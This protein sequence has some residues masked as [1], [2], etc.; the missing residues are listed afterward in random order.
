MSLGADSEVSPVRQLCHLPGDHGTDTVLLTS[1]GTLVRVDADGCTVWIAALN[2]VCGNPGGTWLSVT[3]VDPEIVCLSSS[4][5]IVTVTPIDGQIELVGEFE[6]GLEAGVWSPDREVLSLFTFVDNGEGG[7]NSVLL[8]MNA[9]LEVLAEVVVEENVVAPAEE[10]ESAVSMVW[11]PDGTLC[12]VS[13]VDSSDNV[14]RIRT[15]SREDL[16]LHSVGR[17]E[18]GSGKV[19]PNLLEHVAWA[20]GGCSNLM[21]AVQKKGKRIQQVVFF[22][23]NGLRHREFPLRPETNSQVHATVLGLT[24]N[25]ESDLLAISLREETHDKVQLWHRSNYHWY[26]KKEIRFENEQ[27][28]FV[29]FDLERSHVLYVALES[30]RSCELHWREYDFC[31]DSSTVYTTVNQTARCTAFSIDGCL[32][33][34]T[35]FDKA[36][37]PPPMYAATLT[38]D[39][40]VSEISFVPVESTAVNVVVYL[41]DGTFELLGD[42]EGS[43]NGGTSR[44]VGSVRWEGTNDVDVTSLRQICVM[45]TDDLSLDLIAVACA[46]V[47]GHCERLVEVHIEWDIRGEGTATVIKS[48]HLEGRALRVIHWSDRREGALIQLDDGILLE[49]DKDKMGQGRLLPSEAEPLLEACPWI[50]ALHDA[51]T[52]EG[53]SDHHRKRLVVGRSQRA[54]LY[55]HDR[56]LAD[57]SSSFLLAPSH[58]Y[59]CYITADATCQLRFLPLN[60]LH[61]FD[62]LMGSDENHLLQGYEARNVE[63]GARLVGVLPTKPTSILQMP[64]GNLEAVYPRALVLPYVMSKIKRLEYGEAFVTMRR[65]KVDLNLIVDMDPVHFLEQ[66][67]VEMFLEQVL[68]IDHLNLFISCLQDFDVTVTRYSV[69]AWF[70][71][72]GM[73]EK[74]PDA[75][76][77]VNRVCRVMRQ[78]MLTTEQ[79]G[80]TVGGRQISQGHY[81]LPILSTFAKENP[82]KL[83]EAL[84]LIKQNALSAHPVTSRKPPLFGEKAQ[85]S[86]K[87]LAFLADY[88]LLF[89]TALGMYDFDLSR[90]VA[91]NS[92]MDPKVYLPLLKRLK[93][94]PEHYGKYEVDIR[95]KRYELALAHLVKSGSSGEQ[96]EPFKKLLEGPD[97]FGNEFEQCM[98]LIESQALHRLGLELFEEDQQKRRV[99]LISLGKHLLAK[100]SADTALAVFLSA[101]PPDYEGAKLAARGSGNWRYYFSVGMASEESIQ[102]IE[103][104]N[105][106]AAYDIADEIAAGKDGTMD[107]RA[108]LAQ[109]ARILLDY[110]EDI[111]GAIDMLLRAEMWSE[112]RRISCLHSRH[113]LVKKCIGAA[114][115]FAQSSLDDFEMRKEEFRT[116]NERYIEVLKIRKAAIRESDLPPGD[117]F[118]THID[119]N[120][121]LF[122]MASN[123]SNTSVRS[124]MSG[125]SVGSVTSVSSVI[126][127]SAQSTFSITSEHDHYRHKS[128]FN[129]IGQEKKKKKKKK[130][131][132]GRKKMQPGSEEELNSLVGTLKQSCVNASFASVISD[133]VAYLIEVGKL[134]LA[135]ELYDGYTSMRLMIVE[136]Q[137]ER[138]DAARKEEED[139]ERRARKEGIGEMYIRHPVEA[140]VDNLKCP[141]L[142]SSTQEFFSFLY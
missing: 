13:S 27:M 140:D 33:N 4:G 91:R 53:A 66:G 9:Q 80:S 141:E 130:K 15:Y 65:Q 96:L 81:L 113:D 11:R 61:R 46:P 103:D 32:L 29:S 119:D 26:L 45:N 76:Q 59:L 73:V 52:Y 117:A 135:K 77:K 122:S 42:V 128:K 28:T 142:A 8:S 132:T 2:S 87:Y 63:R 93:E 71:Q 35:H 101:D 40:P 14:R 75:V 41:S 70:D 97:S 34:M 133:T 95:L 134:A 118:D 124:N 107:N 82:P 36:L 68:P 7:K 69:P 38:M 5:A 125:S 56:L 111:V 88:K 39:S 123:A 60:E 57:S 58:N 98:N 104:S 25:T 131:S 3:Y 67:G 89:D 92:Q 20:G 136:L 51:A 72:K 31:W 54:R 43:K 6:H 62:P 30:Q 50:A 17:S 138:K 74:K 120:G 23:S 114:V 48:T 44:I 18:D 115:S 105:R 84:L 55:C 21:T 86:I 12:A 108:C 106:S 16:A 127:V 90:A 24:W 129:K 22:E 19:V 83:E 94:L 78:H 49:F 121:S 110:T 109:A 10:E 64:R 100:R 1:D 79:D 102:S 116:A 99:V 126:S 137:Q 139:T 47:N 37:V 112:A 85:S